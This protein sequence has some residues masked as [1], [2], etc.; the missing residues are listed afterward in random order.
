VSGHLGATHPAAGSLPYPPRTA[1]SFM[2]H[3]I[4]D[5]LEPKELLSA[6][7]AQK[8]SILMRNLD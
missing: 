2:I 8:C 4:V 3:C 1:G 7:N 6:G 5:A